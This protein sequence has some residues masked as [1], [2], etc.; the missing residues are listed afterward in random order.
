MALQKIF[1]HNVRLY[2]YHGL[3]EEEAVLGGEFL[4]NIDIEIKEQQAPFSIHNTI[5]YADVFA[6]LK[7]IFM[8][9]EELLETVAYNLGQAIFKK[10]ELAKNAA[11]SITKVKAPIAQFS[12]TVGVEFTF[13]ANFFK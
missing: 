6:L 2:G 5:N 3:Y 8:Q 10:F 7:E 13:D 4:I 11:I 1:V 9:R 12:G